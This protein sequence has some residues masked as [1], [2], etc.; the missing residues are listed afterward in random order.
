M[1]PTV[2]IARVAALPAWDTTGT[3]HDFYWV[4]CAGRP[5]AGAFAA[6]QQPSAGRRRRTGRSGRCCGFSAVVRCRTLRRDLS[7]THPMSSTAE[8]QPGARD[9]PTRTHPGDGV[10]HEVAGLVAGW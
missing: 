7:G 2:L 3:G 10:P 1:T 6:L 4:L 8:T 5:R 9:P